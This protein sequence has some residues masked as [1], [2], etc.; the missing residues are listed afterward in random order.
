MAEHGHYGGS[1][2]STRQGIYICT[3]GGKFLASVNSNRAERVLATMREGLEAWKKLPATERGLPATTDIKPKHRWE[4]SYPASGLVLT[5]FARDLPESCDPAEPCEVKWNQDRVWFSQEEARRWLP[6]APEVGASYAI[7]KE[8]VHRLARFHLIDTVRGQTSAYRSGDIKKASIAASVTKREGELVT[9]SLKGN[10][11]AESA[12]GFRDEPHAITTQILGNATYD[13]AASVFRSFELVAL[14][15][16]RGWT[17]FNG[18]RG[19]EGTSPVGFVF[20]LAGKDSAKI[21]PAFVFA[22]NADWI[23]RP[24]RRERR[25]NREV[26][27]TKVS[28]T[29]SIVGEWKLVRS[30]SRG[31]PPM[32]LVLASETS[33]TLSWGDRELT[34]EEVKLDGES[35]EFQ[36][37]MRFGD[38]SVPMQFKGTV[39]GSKLKGTL[40]RRRE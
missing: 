15:Q 18:R 39:D 10:T 2:G 21:A 14:G 13:L 29:P 34:L 32:K 30:R 36:V 4:D 37:T 8:L 11:V 26:T 28:D 5:M 40:G 3:A 1:P 17:R 33:G 22:Y 16:R 38:R 23:K 6:D 19:D 20:E 12:G 9:L 25:W 35:L 31:A 27:G 7:P 24:P